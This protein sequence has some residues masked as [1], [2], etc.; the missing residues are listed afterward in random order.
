MRQHDCIIIGAGPCGIGAGLVLKNNNIDV[1]LIN[2]GTIGGKVN[3]APRVDNYPGEHQIPG[4]DLAVKFFMRA[5]E[6][7][8]EI[9][10]DTVLHLTKE[11]E[12]F[13]LVGQF[14]EYYAKAVLIASGTKERKPGLAKEDELLGHGL[15]YCALCDGHFFRG[16]DIAIVGGGNAALKEAIYLSNIVNKLYLVHRRNEFRGSSKLVDELKEKNNVKILTPYVPVEIAGEQ[17]VEGLK[18]RN[19]ADNEEKTL[20]VQGFFPLIGQIPNTQ[21]IGI[22]GVLDD[23]KTIP[24][25]K[26]M[27]SNTNGLFAG[28]DVLPRE[29]RQIYLA[30]HDGKVAAQSIMKYLE[31][32][33]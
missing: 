12:L 22:E 29:I 15:S 6:A 26:E 27:M 2:E 7:K 11:G 24:V 8:L 3:I 10:G 32:L 25:N 23:Y 9:V 28:G 1:I 14:D 4:P 16:K 21:F 18:I 17:E 20:V 13:H 31:A 33:R 5:K 19:V 30:E